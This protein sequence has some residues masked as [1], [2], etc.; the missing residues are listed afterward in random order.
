MMEELRKHIT[1]DQ[2]NND[3]RVIVLNAEGPMFSAGHNLKELVSIKLQFFIVIPI[4]N[5]K[6]L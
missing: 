2:N 5:F 6:F 1:M 3:L 4:R